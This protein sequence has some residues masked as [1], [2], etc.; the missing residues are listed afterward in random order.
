MMEGEEGEGAS[1]SEASPAQ[2]Q[3]KRQQVRVVRCPKC[4]KFLPELPNYSVY[5][6]GGC[7]TTLQGLFY[8]PS[9]VLHLQLLFFCT[10]S[11]SSYQAADFAIYILCCISVHEFFLSLVQG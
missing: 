2:Q 7:G 8:S 3:Q 1:C 6:C 11:I 9:S 10:V 4:D 5:V